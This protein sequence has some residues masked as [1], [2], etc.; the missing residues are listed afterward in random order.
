MNRGCEVWQGVGY[1]TQNDSY[2]LSNKQYLGS[3]GAVQCENV[4]KPPPI[5]PPEG[6]HTCHSR[7]RDIGS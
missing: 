2:E 3:T 7:L 5:D 4:G 1:S 6:F